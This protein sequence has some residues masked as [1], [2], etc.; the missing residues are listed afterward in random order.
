MK[1]RLQTATIGLIILTFISKILGFVR[2]LVISYIYGT[3]AMSDAY[4]MANSIAILIVTGLAMGIM[5]A[6]ILGFIV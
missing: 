4:S 5:T 6:Y 1:K 2:E 3:T